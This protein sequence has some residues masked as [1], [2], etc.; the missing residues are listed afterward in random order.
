MTTTKKKTIPELKNFGKLKFENKIK[1]CHQTSYYIS[2]SIVLPYP[3]F[4]IELNLGR[5]LV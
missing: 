2:D 1:N 4:S 3:K 5:Q